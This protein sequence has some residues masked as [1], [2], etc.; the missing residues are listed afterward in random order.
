M[1]NP[2]PSSIQFLDIKLRET[3]FLSKLKVLAQG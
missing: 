3:T 1:Y 2:F